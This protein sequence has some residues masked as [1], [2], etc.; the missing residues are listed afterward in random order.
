MAS[1]C[2]LLDRNDP[3]GQRKNPMTPHTRSR[4]GGFTLIEVTLALAISGIALVGL[5]AMVPQGVLTMKRATDTAIEAR[6]HQQLVAEVSQTDWQHR[7]GYDYRATTGGVRL[8]DA[9]GIPLAADRQEDAIYAARLI[10]PGAENGG[11]VMPRS[12]PPRLS[13]GS[14]RDAMLFDSKVPSGPG[15]NGN[16]PLQPV[17]VEITSAPSVREVAHFDLP[18]NWAGIRTYRSTMVRTVDAV[19]GLGGGSNP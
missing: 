19:R 2:F 12:L 16:D 18:I 11:T 7:G 9:E 6:I 4:R 14:P 17:I 10:L 8:F 3:L 15:Y 5:L 1:R 13:G